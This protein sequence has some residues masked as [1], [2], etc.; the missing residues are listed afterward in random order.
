MYWVVRI[1]NG[2]YCIQTNGW[3]TFITMLTLCLPVLV[4]GSGNNGVMQTPVIGE[5]CSNYFRG[6]TFEYKLY[7]DS[8]QKCDWECISCFGRENPNCP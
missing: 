7:Y 2:Q 6:S 3:I 8:C 5:Y 4:S 1:S